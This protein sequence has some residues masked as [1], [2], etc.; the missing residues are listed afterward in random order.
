M[1]ESCRPTPRRSPDRPPR[2]RRA[3]VGLAVACSLLAACGGGDEGQVGGVTGGEAV[4]GPLADLGVLT[5]AFVTTFAPF[6]ALA[7]TLREST[8]RYTRQRLSWSFTNRPAVVYSSYALAASRFEYAHAVDLF[9]RGQIV[10]VIDDG[11]RTSHE[12]LGDVDLY[13]GALPVEDHGTIVASIIA[14]RTPDFIGVAPEAG[15][16]LGTFQPGGTLQGLDNLR[17]ATRQ[18]IALGAVAQNNSW[19]YPN[20][21]ATPAGFDAAFSTSQA[22]AYLDALS[23]FAQQ[24]VVVFAAPNS[25][26]GATIMDGLPRVRPDLERGWISVINAVPTFT[27]DRV[28]SA[29]LISAP[30]AQ[31]ARWC[32]AAE[33]VWEGA[34]AASDTSY[35][36]AVGTSF[37]APQV[38][39]ALALLAE[40]FPALTP[41]DLRLRLLASADTSF[42][43]PDRQ[44][45]LAEGFVK[46]YSTTWGHGFLDVR[47]ALLPIGT[48]AVALA[49]GTSAS[50]DQPLILAGAATGDAVTRSLG[51][52]TIVATDLLGGDFAVDAGSLAA[53]A[54]PAPIGP[55]LLDDLMSDDPWASL[56]SGAPPPPPGGA[57]LAALDG[58]AITLSDARDGTYASLLITGP[59]SGDL[60]MSVARVFDT[61]AGALSVGVTL[62][63][64][65]GG[66]FGFGLGGEA[67]GSA[68]AAIDLGLTQSIGQ[69]GYLRLG[70]SFGAADDA[71][72]TRFDA[73]SL[74]VGGSGVAQSGDRLA[75]GVSLPV[76]ATSGQTE[77]ALPVA[78]GASGLIYQPVPIDVA[79][80]DRQVDLSLRYDV[81]V[82]RRADLRLELRHALN[83]GHVAGQTDTAA[84]LALRI[85]F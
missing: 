3:V 40:A 65:G 11:F 22:L 23:D 70:A 21:P 9:G 38:S 61:A 50:L 48:P 32:L 39:G 74:E 12:A 25:G 56:W 59:D 60:G 28:T 37:A 6:E 47:A 71:A 36:L 5:Q 44:V 51:D 29:R 18:A 78:R 34:T 62:G 19:G 54:A 1:T 63:H 84:G 30:C 41:H 42:F 31:S 53:T 66:L 67:T 43:T 10:S 35:G 7:A 77:V 16:A 79:P 52:V 24:G 57:V 76:V 33:G 64:D 26:S 55:A 4:Q 81:P 49:D 68:I 75:F 85:R 45:E 73:V 8:P 17:L 2:P 58:Q 83:H 46:G 20:I 69:G 14:G 15:L 80:E 13:G 82:G 27:E 72:A